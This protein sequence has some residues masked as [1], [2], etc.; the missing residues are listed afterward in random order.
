MKYVIVAVLLLFGACG[1][2]DTPA[3]P[4]DDP[5][6]TERDFIA[7]FDGEK[8]D[9]YKGHPVKVDEA[10]RVVVVGDCT[11]AK[12]LTKSGAPYGPDGDVKGYGY[13]CP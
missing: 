2:D 3:D 7:T 10:T 1:D 5:M 8:V 9:D 12:E 13:V 6:Q 4:S 11:I